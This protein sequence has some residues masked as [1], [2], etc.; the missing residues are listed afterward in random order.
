MTIEELNMLDD[1]ALKNELIKCCGSTRWVKQLIAE[2]P[3]RSLKDIL[4]KAESSWHNTTEA[5]WIEAFSHH[6]KIGDLKNLEKKFASTKAMAGNE[7]SSVNSASLKTLERLAENNALYENKFG[8]IFI[9]CATGKS[10]DEML[11]LLEAR[12][13]N[14]RATELKIASQ[15]QLKITLLRLQKLIS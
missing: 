1:S 2:K 4:L 6:P 9:V 13:N 15:E 10:A 14:D 12:I 7:Q 3:F 8:F 5:D 11:N